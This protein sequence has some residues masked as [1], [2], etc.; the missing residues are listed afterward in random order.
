MDIRERERGDDNRLVKTASIPTP[1]SHCHDPACKKAAAPGVVYIRDDGI[2]IID[3]SKAAGQ[4]SIVSAC[5]IGAVYWNEVLDLPQKCTMCAELLDEGFELP[6]CVGACP[7]DAMFFGDLDDPES[8]VSRKM[9][10]GKVTQL[11]ELG[12]A[13]TNVIHINIPTIFLAGCVYDPD[14]TAV[15]SAC[16]R[17]LDKKNATIREVVTNFF[18]D[19]I[20]EWLDKDAEYELTIAAPGYLPVKASIVADADRYFGE[21]ILSPAVI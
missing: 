17:L 19:W 5:P 1:C 15:E 7:N 9:V 4:R 10:S 20:F 16:V 12:S 14:E 3:P 2:V 6:R 13:L 11:P 18:G 21:T 8:E